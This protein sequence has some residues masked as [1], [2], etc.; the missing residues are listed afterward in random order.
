LWDENGKP[1]PLSK[2]DIVAAM[3]EANRMRFLLED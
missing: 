2:I 1:Y 3:G